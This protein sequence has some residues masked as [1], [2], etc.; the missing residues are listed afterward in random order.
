MNQLLAI[1][2]VLLGCA[3]LWQTLMN[4]RLTQRSTYIL[5]AT[6]GIVWLAGIVLFAVG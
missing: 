2:F 1:V 3:L 6:S 4:D 5:Y